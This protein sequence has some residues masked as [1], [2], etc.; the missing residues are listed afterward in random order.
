MRRLLV[1]AAMGGLLSGCGS[2]AGTLPEDAARDQFGVSASRPG[3]AGTSDPDP[4]VRQLLDWHAS[5]ICTGG[6]D[7]IQQSFDQ[8]EAGQ[9]IV[10]WTVRCRPYRLA[11]PIPFL[12]PLTLP[13]LF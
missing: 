11:L 8:A 6:Y 1:V 5:Q 13:S 7:F 4:Q 10:D 9:Q 3:S 12:P 2:L